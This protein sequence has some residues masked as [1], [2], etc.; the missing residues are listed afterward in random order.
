MVWTVGV[1]VTVDVGF[2]VTSNVKGVPGQL[3][4][5]GPVGVM[6]Y[7]TTPDDVPEFTKVW[8]ILVPQDEEQSLKP[9]IVPPVGAVNRDAVHVKVVPV[10]AEVIV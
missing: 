5:A 8:P 1:G 4:D 7:L 6:I 10:V 3:V 2:T 9:V